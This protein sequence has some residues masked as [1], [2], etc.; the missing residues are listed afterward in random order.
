VIYLGVLF[1]IIA[2]LL[3]LYQWRIRQQGIKRREELRRKLQER[4]LLP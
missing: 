2:I 1:V 4:G 3:P